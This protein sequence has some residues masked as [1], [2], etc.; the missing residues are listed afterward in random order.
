M[1]DQKY[2]VLSNQVGA[3]GSDHWADEET[4]NDVGTVRLQSYGYEE[5]SAKTGA[6]AHMN[7][8]VRPGRYVGQIRPYGT[9]KLSLNHLPLQ[10]E[11][12][13]HGW[14]HTQNEV[15]KPG[16]TTP[17]PVD[18]GRL[19]SQH[20]S[21]PL[22][23]VNNS[24]ELEFLE[25]QHG[26]RLKHPRIRQIRVCVGGWQHE[27]VHFPTQEGS[28]ES[29]QTRQT[30]Q[31]HHMRHGSHKLQVQLSQLSQAEK[32]LAALESQCSW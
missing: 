16:R 6:K 17:E 8:T 15:S 25:Y 13:G 9:K 1:A 32:G 21:I 23:K 22:V 31:F 5:S 10:L 18:R 28:E 27:S 29:S 24:Q 30:A 14:Y 12:R 20:W 3:L 4:Q 26:N 2:K 19:V 7:K 11:L